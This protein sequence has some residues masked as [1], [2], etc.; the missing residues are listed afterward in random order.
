MIGIYG[1]LVKHQTSKVC[2]YE[3]PIKY[4]VVINDGLKITLLMY[5]IKYGWMSRVTFHQCLV[6]FLFS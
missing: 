6:V 3:N 5:E 1:I 2:T 4:E